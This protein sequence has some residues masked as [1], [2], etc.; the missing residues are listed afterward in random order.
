M[1]DSVQMQAEE[2]VEPVAPSDDRVLVSGGGGCGGEWVGM[3]SLTCVRILIV[4]AFI[5]RAFRA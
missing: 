2:D 5:T 4:H 1:V 3:V